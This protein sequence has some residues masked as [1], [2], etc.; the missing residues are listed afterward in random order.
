MEVVRFSFNVMGDAIRQPDDLSADEK[1]LM[2]RARN[3]NSSNN[4][5]SVAGGKQECEPRQQDN[6]LH[7]S[8]GVPRVE[9]KFT[10]ISDVSSGRG[11]IE[12]STN[13][14]RARKHEEKEPLGSWKVKCSKKDQNTLLNFK[15]GVIDPSGMLASWSV[16]QDCCQWKGIV[17]DSI[18]GRVTGLSLP[19]STHLSPYTEKEDKSHCLTGEIHPSLLQLE[20]L[21]YLNL[22]HNDFKAIQFDSVSLPWSCGD[23]SNSNLQY[24]DLSYNNDLHIENL[25]WLSC[26]SSLKYLQLSAIDLHRETSWLQSLTMLPKLSELYLKS[27]H[28]GKIYPSLEYANFTSLK[29]LDLSRNGFNSEFPKWLF[30]LSCDISKIDLH[31]NLLQGQIPQGQALLNLRNLK[32]L[33][34][35]EN[36]LKGLIPDWLGQ[37]ENPQELFL[38][39]NLFSGPIPTVLG[40]LSS[41]I[42]LDLSSNHLNGSVPDTLWQLSNLETLV[43]GCNFLTGVV[44]ERN[45]VKLQNLKQLYL[46]SPSLTLDF[47]SQWIPPFQL[48]SITLQYLGGKFPAWIYTQRSL[49]YL[50]ICHSSISFKS[51]DKFWNFAAQ[52]ELF[53]LSH[54]Q[55]EGNLSDVV[56]QSRIIYVSSNKLRGGLP[57]ISPNVTVFRMDNNSLSGPISPLLCPKI[58]GKWNLMYLDISHNLLSGELPDCWMNWKSLVHVYMRYNNLTGK[59]PLSMSSLSNLKSLDL[60]NNNLFGGI[61]G[62][63]KNCQKLQILDLGENKF[64]GNIPNWIRHSMKVLRLRSNQFSGRIPQEICQL[65]SLIVLDFADNRISGPMPNCLHD[66]RALVFKNASQQFLGFPVENTTYTFIYTLALPSKG[67]QRNYQSNQEFMRVIDLSQNNLSGLIPLEIFTLAAL[68]SL[69]LSQNQLIGEIPEDIGNLKQLESL[70]L[71]NNHLFGEIPQSISIMSFLGVLNLSFNNF[72]GQIPTGTQLQSFD[73]LSFIGNL[74]LCGAPLTKNCT[75]EK[76]SNSAKLKAKNEDDSG[77]LSWLYIG[78]EVGFPTGFLGVCYVLYFGKT[79]WH[80]SLWRS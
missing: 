73:A 72:S 25:H 44:S 8:L 40:N 17:R 74:E 49:V 38:D 43:I 30:N 46:G 61:P 3:F 41:L 52:L 2:A 18:T 33:R 47:N 20:F 15:R 60:H 59:I 24:L 19:C 1:V 67:Q 6:S 65:S 51:Q 79:W 16:E 37:L 4:G 35:T 50:T 42:T 76:N 9:D 55:I 54:N 31:T 75:E 69:N 39:H 71:S 29:V 22:S 64:S 48:V 62:S 34:L 32:F 23:S 56:L 80:A 26:F 63:L 28:L 68:Q 11:L 12:S 10:S 78:L 21:N 66:I 7:S 58:N 77:F 13:S 70:D 45:F 57:Q 14:S 36:K 53:H 5:G 27:C